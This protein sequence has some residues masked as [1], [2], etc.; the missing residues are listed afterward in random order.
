MIVG[1]TC[2]KHPGALT[3]ARSCRENEQAPL[4]DGTSTV[5]LFNAMLVI[6]WSSF[7]DARPKMKQSVRR[8][9][10]LLVCSCI[11]RFTVA[12]ATSLLGWCLQASIFYPPGREDRDTRAWREGMPCPFTAGRCQPSPCFAVAGDDMRLRMR[13]HCQDPLPVVVTFATLSQ[14]DSI[15]LASLCWLSCQF[16]TVA[17]AVCFG[18]FFRNSSHDS[19]VTGQHFNENNPS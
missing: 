15:P 9:T 12:S 10:T 18:V 4:N 6:A 13:Y 11:L 16:T 2:L 5:H 3:G 14:V 7:A 1:S 19:F 8:T 17:G